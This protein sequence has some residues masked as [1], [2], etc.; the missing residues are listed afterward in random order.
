MSRELE[1]QY[2]IPEQSRQA[3]PLAALLCSRALARGARLAGGKHH[4][5]WAA[6]AADTRCCICP[7]CQYRNK[8]PRASRGD[9]D[10]R[11]FTTDAPRCIV[12]AK[13]A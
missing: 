11:D 9:F 5:L 6:S 1:P 3:P 4:R 13:K 10:G 12:V 8:S 2:S 7:A